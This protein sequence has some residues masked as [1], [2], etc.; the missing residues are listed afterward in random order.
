MKST[1]KEG[2]G[3]M[4]IMIIMIIILREAK[5]WTTLGFP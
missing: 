3:G 4:I 5:V 2:K 1:S